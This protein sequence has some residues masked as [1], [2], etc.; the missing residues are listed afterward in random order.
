MLVLLV[1]G[2]IVAKGQSDTIKYELPGDGTLVKNGVVVDASTELD[3]LPYDIAWKF[4]KTGGNANAY[5]T[6][7]DCE[8]R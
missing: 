1:G 2:A 5:A 7:A 3:T 4:V 6:S 8:R